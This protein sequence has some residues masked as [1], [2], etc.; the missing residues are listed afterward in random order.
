MTYK[1][2]AC[3]ILFGLTSD[4]LRANQTR[5]FCYSFHYNTNSSDNQVILMIYC[6]GLPLLLRRY[7]QK[8]RVGVCGSLPKTFTVV[9]TK[10]CDFPYPIHDLTKK[11]GFPI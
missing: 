11:I 9:M 10:F 6:C 3:T 1:H 5:E 2:D 7:S 8:N 4:L